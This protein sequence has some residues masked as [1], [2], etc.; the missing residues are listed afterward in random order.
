MA[1]HAE[2]LLA[3]SRGGAAVPSHA[4]ELLAISRGG[5]AVPSHVEELPASTREEAAVPSVRYVDARVSRHRETWEEVFE[6]HA[7]PS[8]RKPTNGALR[9]ARETIEEDAS[10]GGAAVPPH[11]EERLAIS[12]GG[13]A[14]PSHAEELLAILLCPLMRRSCPLSHVEELLCHLM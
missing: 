9:S 12:R 6:Q 2:E 4:E 1:S 11:V 7:V 8:L 10:R 5:A 14:V 3:I 13:A